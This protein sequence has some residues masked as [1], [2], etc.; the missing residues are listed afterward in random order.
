MS[1]CKPCKT[2]MS[3]STKLYKDLDGKSIDHKLYRG[4]IGSLLYLTSSQPDIMFSVCACARFQANPKESHL[5][6]VKRI[7]RYLKNT[8]NLGI[9]Y[10]RNS[11]YELHA[12]TDADFAGC[13][14]DRKSTSESCCFLGTSIIT[15]GSKKQNSIALS[16]AEAEYIASGS[17]CAQILWIRQQLRDYQIS[18]SSTILRCDNTSAIEITKNP[19]HHSRTKHIDLRYHFIR[20]QVNQ[21]VITLEYVPTENQLADLFTKPLSTE[22]F[23]MLVREIGMRILD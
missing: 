22:R 12:Y 4:M 21:K 9:W 11:P 1:E 7:L 15:W 20:D 10:D 3:T 6:A 8:Q 5:T 23:N 16:T 17:C 18:C 13:L 19:I 14:V 2:P